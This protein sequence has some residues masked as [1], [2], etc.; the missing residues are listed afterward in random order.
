[1]PEI[2]QNTSLGDAEESQSDNL[3]KPISAADEKLLRQIRDDYRYCL[4]YWRENREAMAKDMDYVANQPWTADEQEE[5]KGRPCLTA[6]QLSQYVKQACNNLRQNKRAI[7]VMPR[8]DGATDKDANRRAA[9]IRGVEYQSNAQ[10]AYTRGF[11]AAVESSMGAWRVTTERVKGGKRGELQPRIKSIP[12]QFTVLFDPNAKEADFSDQTIC[13]VTDVLRKTEFKRKYPNASKTSFTPD[14]NTMAP[15]WFVDDENIVIAEYWHVEVSTRKKMQLAGPAGE[16][17]MYDDERPKGDTSKVLNDWTEE[18]RK[19]TQYI[20]NGVEI[21]ER[22]D[23]AG[24]WIPIIGVFGEE[25]Y[26]NTSGRAKRMFLSLI[27]RA[28]GPQKMLCFIASQEAEEF[29]MAPRAPVILYEGQEQADEQNWKFLNKQPLAYIKIKPTYGENGELLPPPTQFPFQ[30]NTQAYE[31]SFEKW[32]RQIQASIGIAPLP[33]SAQRQNEKSGVAL[34][35]IQTQE[36]TGSFH[37]TDNLDRSLENT[38]R[39]LNELISICMDTPQQVGTRQPD[40]THALM[41]V[42]SEAN[43][44]A[45]LAQF[46]D[47]N[48]DDYLVV[49]RG[50]F[51][52]TIDTGPSQQSER[53]MNSDFVDTLLKELAAYGEALKDPTIRA[54]L[55][56]AIK[57]K[58]VGP[59]GDQMA[60]LLMPPDQNNLPPEVQAQMQ[61]LQSQ[62]QQSQ[63]ELQKLAFEK[64]AK[65]VDNQ[66]KMATEELK[67]ATQKAI[68]ELKIEADLAIA[69][70]ETKSQSL[71]ERLEFVEDLAKQFHAQAHE[72]GMQAEEHAQ[73]QTLGAQQASQQSAQS[74]QEGG[75]QAALA[76]Q[77]AGHAQD[78]AQTNADLA[79]EPSE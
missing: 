57:L 25:I 77:S 63:T 40:E 21:L 15:D 53:D 11:E 20:T 34:E 4:D 56:K 78:L 38:G 42:T 46:P 58:G 16:T 10:S 62:I 55:A 65:I 23:W 49:D 64:Q 47:T 35:K 59:I 39:Q 29:G 70:V 79:P 22:N 2:P 54:M 69:E 61:Q 1:M 50:E 24:S 12:N 52:V 43:L 26:V 7:K 18:K 73:Q 17:T 3:A 8:G 27:R 30:I 36:A 51:D 6:D 72:R 31:L 75:Q 44:Q 60:D 76:D 68:A 74:L 66:H 33:T 14:D 9:I 13:F 71:S 37:F 5:R 41:H 67:T 48:E 32:R 19:I 28:L 45:A